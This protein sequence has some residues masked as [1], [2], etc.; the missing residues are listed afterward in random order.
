MSIF[1]TV[2]IKVPGLNKFDLSYSDF[3]TMNTGTL[4]V[5]GY[6]EMIPGDKFRMKTSAFVRLMP[7]A[8]PAFQNLRLYI[9]YFFV[10]HR[11][12]WDD[13]EDFITD[14]YQNKH[15]LP[16]NAN[17]PQVP[18]M[19]FSPSGSTLSQ[20][21]LLSDLNMIV[22]T[23]YSNL[24][25]QFVSS[26]PLRSYWL[27]YNEWYRDQNVDN[28]VYFPRTGGVEDLSNW[29]FVTPDNQVLPIDTNYVFNYGRRR[30]LKDYFTSA[31][32][33]PQKGPDV[34]LPFGGDAPLSTTG[35][36]K[37]SGIDTGYSTIDPLV[38]EA[39]ASSTADSITLQTGIDGK[40]YN[41]RNTLSNA[42][43]DLS[44]VTSATIND[45]RRAVAL[46]RFFEVSARGGSR[47]IEVILSHFG[48]HSKDARLQRPEFLGGGSTPI[49]VGE[50]LQ[51]TPTDDSPLAT[52]AGR[53]YA[54]ADADDN[55]CVYRATEHGYLMCIASI[56]PESLYFQGID[57]SLQRFDR[58]DFY[59]PE[60]AHLGEQEIKK[61]ELFY[62]GTISDDELFGYSPR[63]AEYKHSRNSLHGE[64]LTNPQ[65]KTWHFGR[66]FL[67]QPSLN[68]DFLEIPAISGPF[69]VKDGDKFIV[70]FYHQIDALRPMPY[71]SNPSLI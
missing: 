46:Q 69:A 18:T 58:L 6:K 21:R 63:Y 51:T 34:M 37:Y 40:L 20:S 32:P 53:G 60:F 3:T 64:F 38:V 54:F 70:D 4:Q 50:V 36:D 61:K 10:P 56:V 11:L 23:P 35:A 62:S 65:L 9:H 15:G 2:N 67:N 55:G 49:Q 5:A 25:L 14:Q 27:I 8:S 28:L 30:Y 31:L 71:H 59:W 33:W 7:M 41:L 66:E 29:K 45:L 19:E 57:R 44:N 43:V 42:R 39:S 22:P 12:V 16:I 48:V 47:Y 17:P 1:N 52:M 24:S 13:F 68:S 26:L